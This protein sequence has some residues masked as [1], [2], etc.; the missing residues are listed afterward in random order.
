MLTVSGL[1]LRAGARLL[2]ESATFRVAAGDRVGAE[3]VEGRRPLGVTHVDRRQAHPAHSGGVDDDQG[4]AHGREQRH[5]HDQLRTQ[6]GPA[7]SS[8]QAKSSVPK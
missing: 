5:H 6:P 4:D 2:L 8:H 1:E 3:L 7:A